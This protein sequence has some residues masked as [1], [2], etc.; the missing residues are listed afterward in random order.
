MTHRQIREV[1]IAT[2]SFVLAAVLATALALAS[3]SSPPPHFP[4]QRYVP[5][6]RAMAPLGELHLS[7][8]QMRL[9]ALDGEMKLQYVG[10]MPDSGG[11]DMAGG[12]V[13]R[14]KNSDR[15][16][17]QN[18]GRNAWCGEPA[19]WVVVNSETGAPAWSREIFMGLLTVKEWSKFTPSES[20]FCG[21]G[22][23]VRSRN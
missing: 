10:L 20:G 21:G 22:N 12:S 19:L 2:L 5:V 6:S 15:Y 3:C 8:T 23:Y 17:K 4:L 16:F 14:V 7:S 9:G 13:Y 18:E 1:S 11:T